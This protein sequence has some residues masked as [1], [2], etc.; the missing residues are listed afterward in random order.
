MMMIVTVREDSGA[1][2]FQFADPVA[3][4]LDAAVQSGA[5][6]REQILYKLVSGALEYVLYDHSLGEKYRWHPTLVRWARSLLRL[7]RS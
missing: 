2:R 7:S 5:L 3:E 4:M 1:P 6:S